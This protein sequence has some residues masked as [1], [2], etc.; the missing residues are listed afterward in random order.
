MNIS[1]NLLNNI[2]ELKKISPSELSEQLILAG[3]E[4]ENIHYLSDT[5]DIILDINITSNRKDTSS[6][7]GLAEEISSIVNIPFKTIKKND[8]HYKLSVISNNASNTFKQITITVIENICIQNSPIHIQQYLK[9]HGIEVCNNIFDIVNFTNLKWGQ[10]AFF[11]VLNT[12][13]CVEK[14]I[15]YVQET[16]DNEGNY[17][18]ILHFNQNNISLVNKQFNKNIS[19]NNNILSKINLLLI[20]QIKQLDPQNQYEKYC[21]NAYY[22]NLNL[23][24]E[25]FNYEEFNTYIYTNPIAKSAEKKINIDIRKIYETLGPC[26]IRLSKTKEFL[27]VS[28]IFSLLQR[29][30]LNP[31]Y[32]SNDTITVSVPKKRKNDLYRDIDIIEEIGRIYGFNQFIDKIP[33]KSCQGKPSYYTTTKN[34]IRQILRSIGLHEIIGYSLIKDKNN[35]SSI[36]LYNPLNKELAILRNTLITHLIE[37]SL[38]NCNQGNEFLEGFEIGK[39]FIKNNYP[40]EKTYLSGVLGSNNYLR[41]NWQSKPYSLSWFQAKGNLEEFFERINIKVNWSSKIDDSI[42]FK[43][44]TQYLRPKK[45]CLIIFNNEAIGILG[46]IN[47]QIMQKMNRGHN[48]YLFEIDITKILQLNTINHLEYNYK[49]YSCYPS[50]TRDISVNTCK[51]LELDKLMTIIN[52]IKKQKNNLI[53]SVEIFDEYIEKNNNI[54]KKIGLRITYRSFTKTLTSEEIDVIEKYIKQELQ[55]YL[56]LFNNAKESR[57]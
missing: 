56:L 51:N 52:K 40:Q 29:L 22:D 47:N 14:P 50:I 36:N 8:T 1:W 17:H 43:N 10:N 25:Y 31:R 53:K 16:I 57:T 33:Q 18:P 2:L 39:V 45:S 11:V 34:K 4:V 3:F 27:N 7:I 32:N 6:I 30:N 42:F 35:Q 13:H 9:V 37:I 46:E 21:L 54:T 20:N 23:I 48:I 5:K 41:Y 15:I 38:Y 28:K 26:K 49:P 24:N 55:F 19:N 12:N 44:L